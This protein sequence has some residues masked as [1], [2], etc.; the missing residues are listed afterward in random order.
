MYLFPFTLKFVFAGQSHCTGCRVMTS[1]GRRQVL[2][3]H[4]MLAFYFMEFLSLKF[5]CE[6]ISINLILGKGT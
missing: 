4:V 3:C 1:P 2:E 6:V 5:K